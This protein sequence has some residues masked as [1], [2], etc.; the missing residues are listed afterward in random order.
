[1][2]FYTGTIQVSSEWWA[3]EACALFA[4]LLGPVVLACQSIM[5]SCGSV[6]YQVPASL[7]I[8]TSVRVGN[9]LGAGRSFEACWASRAALIICVFFALINR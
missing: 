6:L 8:A 9:L 1:M 2:T 5:L 7:G 3:W 4:S